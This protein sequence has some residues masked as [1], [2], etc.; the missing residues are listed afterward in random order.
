MASFSERHFSHG[1]WPWIVLVTAAFVVSTNHILG[2][3]IIGEIPP[4]GLAFWRVAVGAAVVLPFAWRELVRQRDVIARH[5]K[6]FALMAAA[7]MPAGNAMVYVAYNFTTAINGSIILTAQPALTLVA[8]WLVVGHTINRLQAAG[9]AFAMTGV[10]VIILGSNY[11]ALGTL[12]LSAGDLIMIV[13]TLGFAFYTAMIPRVPPQ[14]GAMLILVIIQVLG[15]IVLLPFYIVESIV[16]MPVPATLESLLVIAWVGTAI[17]VVA[18]GLNNI[19]V[20]AL[21]PAKATIGLYLRT[22]FVTVLAM[23]LLGEPLETFHFVA[24]ALIM[25]G[26]VLMTRGR[27]RP[28][29]GE[30]R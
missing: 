3:Y 25:I 21:G 13:G 10:L 30:A 29:T 24:F 9:T 11:A 22:L 5:W 4:V 16:Y 2:R 19:A 17:A 12:A 27:S 18:V 7:L 26:I 23:A 28:R 14:I 1:P 15:V 6:L 8:A 20:L